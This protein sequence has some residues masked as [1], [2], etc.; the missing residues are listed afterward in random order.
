MPPLTLRDPRARVTERPC[1]QLRVLLLTPTP[2]TPTKVDFSSN[3]LT[4]AN[5]IKVAFTLKKA[6]TVRVTITKT[7]KGKTVTVATVNVKRK[8]G[9]GTYTLRTKVGGK[10][11]KKGKYKVSLQT[12]DGKKTSKA[13]S[14]KVNV[15]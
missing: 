3:T 11:L 7:V 1:P 9:K 10:T 5:P 6:G 2:S 12:V 14:E 13:V 8:A 15:R 4:K